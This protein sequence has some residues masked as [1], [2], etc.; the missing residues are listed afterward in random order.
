VLTAL[1]KSPVVEMNWGPP[2]RW[3]WGHDWLK[4]TKKGTSLVFV[5]CQFSQNGVSHD[6]EIYCRELGSDVV[7]VWDRA[8][9]RW[10]NYAGQPIQVEKLPP[11]TR[12][13]APE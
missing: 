4:G 7:A 13:F 12:F 5:R 6:W 8:G 1:N 9:Q 10:L 11:G 3:A 2:G